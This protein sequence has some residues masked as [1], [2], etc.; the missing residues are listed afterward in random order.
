RPWPGN[1]RELQNVLERATALAWGNT[2]LPAHFQQASGHGP[3]FLNPSEKV[4][5]A[6]EHRSG[7]RRNTGKRAKIADDYEI[8][9]RIQQFLDQHP[10]A[11]IREV[12]E[13]V[14]LSV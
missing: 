10:R 3:P 14:G 8:N 11:T 4:R 6:S 1:V 13:E 7:P 12:A 5:A 2:L 9:G